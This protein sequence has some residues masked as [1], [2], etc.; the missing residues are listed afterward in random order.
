MAA[1]KANYHIEVYLH[2]LDGGCRAFALIPMGDANEEGLESL[3]SFI[4]KHI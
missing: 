2:I 1:K 4:K 3:I